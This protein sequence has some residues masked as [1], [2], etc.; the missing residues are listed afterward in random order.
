MLKR[1]KEKFGKPS[2]VLLIYTEGKHETEFLNY[3]KHYLYKDAVQ[4]CGQKTD[5]VA[6]T[7]STPR[8][9]LDGAITRQEQKNIKKQYRKE[10]DNIIVVVDK[11]N[12]GSKDEVA[13]LKKQAKEN[14][15]ALII[16]EPCLEALLLSIIESNKNFKNEKCSGK[17]GLKKKFESKYLS[18][19]KRT[20]AENYKPHFPL[21]KIEKT[22]K[23]KDYNAKQLDFLIKAMHNEVD[24]DEEN[25]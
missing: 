23:R 12:I 5:I 6:G 25:C 17:T 1:F 7:G 21:E 22:R 19:T 4:G 9:V 14:N 13:K 2:K 16:F 24:F 3:L 20:T 11:D 15:V 18:R 10:Y 8:A